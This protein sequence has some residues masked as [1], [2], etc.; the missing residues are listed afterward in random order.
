[1]SSGRIQVVICRCCTESPKLLDIAKLEAAANDAELVMS[2]KVVDEICDG[3]AVVDVAREA[4]EKEIDR[5]VVLACHKRDVSPALLK[6]Y[7]RAGIDR[8]MVEFVNVREEVVLPHVD[9]PEGAQKKAE[10]KLKA[11]LGRVTMLV[12]LLTE[13]EEMR[14]KNVVIIGAGVAGMAAAEAAARAGAHTVIIEKSSRSVKAPGILMSNT[15]LVATKGT[16]GNYELTIM[17]GEKTEE[18][19]CAAVVVATGGGWNSLKGPLAKASKDAVPLYKLSEMLQA[20]HAPKG[21]VVI[22]DTP[23]P[24]GKSL[25]VMDFAWDEALMT[26]IDVKKKHPQTEVF[27]L[28]QEMRAFGLSEITYKE[29]AELGIR[30]VRYDR[31]GVPKVDP[32][33]PTKMTVTDLAQGELLSVR[34]GTLAFAAIPANPDNRDIA[35]ALRIPMTA[36]GG[37][38]RGGIQRWPVA[39]PRPGIF[40]CGS[41]VFPKSADAARAEGEAAGSMAAAYASKGTVEY[42]GSVAQVAQEKCSACLT[43]IR[44]CPYEAPYIGTANKVE[45][46]R[47]LC[48]GC[49]ICAG[50]CPSKAIELLHYT[51]DQI[52]QET[53][54]MLGGDF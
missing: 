39:T 17:A 32:K 40:V 19:E 29:A 7:R 16:P 30:F 15:R 11:A 8:S 13:T 51:D 26:A 43:C 47:Q 10:T 2:V 14:T 6:A 23:D 9:D 35:D 34:L 48:Q 38:R 21:P 25:K 12:P 36:E 5:A 22:V 24:T 18:L 53:R 4:A 1:M 28:F 54:T 20:G 31:T 45:I 42:G 46:R 50:I 52:Q 3:K 49:G 33:D 37:L 44:T 27:M 41:A